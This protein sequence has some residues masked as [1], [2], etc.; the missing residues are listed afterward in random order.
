MSGNTPLLF[1]S[2]HI[3]FYSLPCLYVKRTR[4]SYLLPRLKGNMLR[5][6]KKKLIATD[7]ECEVLCYIIPH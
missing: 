2:R 6:L 1:S 4:N 7:S 3:F 5:F